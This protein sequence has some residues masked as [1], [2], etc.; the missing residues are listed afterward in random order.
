MHVLYYSYFLK[1]KLSLKAD[2]SAAQQQLCQQ[3]EYCAKMGA[4][5]CTL[6]WRVSQ[7]QDTI[8]PILVGVSQKAY[9]MKIFVKTF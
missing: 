5:C 6:L 3:S 9:I 2:L 1:E 4:A 8:A 7:Q